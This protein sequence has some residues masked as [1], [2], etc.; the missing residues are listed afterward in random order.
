MGVLLTVKNADFSTNAIAFSAPVA[1]GLEYWNYFG[2]TT[3]TGRNLVPGKS[4][5][6][7]V[8]TP[9]MGSGFATFTNSSNYVVTGVTDQREVTLLSVA[10]ANT[11]SQNLSKAMISTYNGGGGTAAGSSLFFGGG[12]GAQA[13]VAAARNSGGTDAPVVTSI[14]QDPNTFGFFTSRIGAAYHR[15]DDKTHN[16]SGSGSVANPRSA[17]NGQLYRVGGFVSGF[18]AGGL[19]DIAFAA[20]YSRVLTDAEVDAIYQRVKTYLAGKGITI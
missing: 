2:D 20:I 11:P 6:T 3:K 10:R 17:A 19:A 16:L 12:G 18:T 4:A 13:T 15:I 1:D 14:T 7:V 8:G 5:G 9:A